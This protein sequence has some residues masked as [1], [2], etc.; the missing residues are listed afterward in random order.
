MTSAAGSTGGA[1]TLLLE[2]II[3]CLNHLPCPL[4][5]EQ[6]VVAEADPFEAIRWRAETE[7]VVVLQ[8]RGVVVEYPD[9]YVVTHDITRVAVAG[10]RFDSTVRLTRRYRLPVR[11]VPVAAL[12]CRSRR[13]CAVRRRG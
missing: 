8:R 5:D 2:E 7:V 13:L 11:A 9:R 4:V 3:V 10:R 6:C 12:G 1:S